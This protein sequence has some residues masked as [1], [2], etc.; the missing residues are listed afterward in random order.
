MFGFYSILLYLYNSS[1]ATFN[2]INQLQSV[3]M[4]KEYYQSLQINLIRLNFDGAVKGIT[5][6]T[7]LGGTL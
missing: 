6:P 1:M 7:S 2:P 4:A 5:R 3:V